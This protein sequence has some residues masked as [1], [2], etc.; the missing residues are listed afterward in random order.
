MMVTFRGDKRRWST[1]AGGYIFV[2]WV[3]MDCTVS[4]LDNRKHNTF[5]HS[6]RFRVRQHCVTSQKEYKSFSEASL[7]G[8]L[9]CG[10]PS[11][12][13]SLSLVI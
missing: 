9:T 5:R 4:V 13:P 3:V 1:E 12:D 2:A 11:L 6:L 7:F 8:I 10:C